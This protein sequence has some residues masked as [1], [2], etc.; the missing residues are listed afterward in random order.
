MK[1]V[2]TKGVHMTANVLFTETGRCLNILLV[3]GNWFTC[4]DRYITI[5]RQIISPSNDEWD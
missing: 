3:M 5:I 1:A 2:M 4:A